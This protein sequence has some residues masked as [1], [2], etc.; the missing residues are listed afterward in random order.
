MQIAGITKRMAVLA[1]G[2]GA[3]GVAVAFVFS[4]LNDDVAQSITVREDGVV[5]SEESLAE[6]LEEASSRAG[7][8]VVAP[9]NEPQGMRVHDIYVHP[10]LR[11]SPGGPVSEFRVVS[12]QLEVSG[13]TF[14]LDELRGGFN[15]VLSGEKL[16]GVVS[17]ADV[18]YDETDK[19]V[20]Y[21]MLTKDRGFILNYPKERALSRDVTLAL[22][23]SFANEL[24]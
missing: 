22:L 12:L 3:I 11:T 17:D 6:A 5:I 20:V 4:S 15:P 1:A 7:F 9:R 21:S 16:E 18:Y 13:L 14:L 23:S 8:A 19:A 2:G 24:R 10:E